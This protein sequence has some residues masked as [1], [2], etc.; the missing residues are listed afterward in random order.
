MDYRKGPVVRTCILV[1]KNI[2]WDQETFCL[3]SQKHSWKSFPNKIKF[4][5][6]TY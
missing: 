6:Y 2:P 1:L 5:K 3:F 4:T